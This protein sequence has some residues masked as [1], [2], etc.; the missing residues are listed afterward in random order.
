[1]IEEVT[2]LGEDGTPAFAFRA[3]ETIRARAR[4]RFDETAPSP[5]FACSLRLPDGQIVYDYTTGWAGV[6]T[7]TFEPRSIADVEFTLTL[8]LVSGAYQLGLDLAYA[9]LSCYY[10]RMVRAVDF[11]VTGC[12]GARG[13]ADLGARFDVARAAPAEPALSG[14]HSTPT[15]LENSS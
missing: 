7:S 15:S 1:M 8:N 3:G 4:I 6:T 5:V 13:V 11:V 10:D 2:L 14:A 9:D 12:D